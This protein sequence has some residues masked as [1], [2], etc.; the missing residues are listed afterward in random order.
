MDAA[1]TIL[2]PGRH[3]YL[4]V[5]FTKQG[6]SKGQARMQQGTSKEDFSQNPA[7][8][9]FMT[10]RYGGAS[11]LKKSLRLADG[12][13][14]PFEGAGRVLPQFSAAGTCSVAAN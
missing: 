12:V 2:S 6:S 9:R 14:Q 4:G 11:F 1:G 13:C 3:P 7:F 5:V 8:C 10:P